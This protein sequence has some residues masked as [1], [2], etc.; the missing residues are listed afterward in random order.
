[1]F[2]LQ[3][4]RKSQMLSH[5]LDQTRVDVKKPHS[6]EFEF[7]FLCVSLR[8]WHFGPF[9]WIWR[10]LSFL[11][12]LASRPCDDV[13]VMSAASNQPCWLFSNLRYKW[14]VV[15]LW[16]Y[17]KFMSDD[18]VD[19]A[20]ALVHHVRLAEIKRS[21]SAQEFHVSTRKHATVKSIVLVRNVL[22]K[23]NQDPGHQL[24]DQSK[25]LGNTQPNPW[26]HIRSLSCW[27]SPGSNIHARAEIK[28]VHEWIDDR[29]EVPWD[30]SGCC[31][32]TNHSIQTV[33]S[34]C[35]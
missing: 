18:F 34:W 21:I 11:F 4:D 2:Y 22:K 10:N 27:Y 16:R 24:I 13:M 31:H 9:L 14:Q 1:M 25:P 3:N 19:K 8:K 28:W 33:S 15:Y 17:N 6:F 30:R 32:A 29:K 20:F 12:P 5:N 35:W 23:G 7:R 26:N